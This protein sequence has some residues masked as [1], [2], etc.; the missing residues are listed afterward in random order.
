M[1]LVTEGR[2]EL[3]GDR[4]IVRGGDT[5]GGGGGT[6]CWLRL[7]MDSEEKSR[8]EGLRMDRG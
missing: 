4:G 7:E 1:V 5:P 6:Q 2:L 3:C 8:V